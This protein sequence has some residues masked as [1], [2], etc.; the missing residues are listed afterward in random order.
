MLRFGKPTTSGDPCRC[1]LFASLSGAGTACWWRR[2]ASRLLR[3]ERGGRPV[4]SAGQPGELR[5][6]VV[7][8]M[9]SELAVGVRQVRFQFEQ[10][11]PAARAIFGAVSSV[12]R[13][14][15]ISVSRAVSLPRSHARGFRVERRVPFEL[16]ALGDVLDDAH[17]LVGSPMVTC[18]HRTGNGS[19]DD[20][21]VSGDE[22]RFGLVPLDVSFGRSVVEL[23]SVFQIVLV[24]ERFEGR[25]RA[26][27]PRT[28]EKS[29]ESRSRWLS[30]GRDRGSRSRWAP[31]ESST[32]P[33]DV[34]RSSS[35]IR[36]RSVT[37]PE[38]PLPDRRR[39]SRCAEASSSARRPGRLGIRARPCSRLRGCHLARPTL[40]VEMLRASQL[41]RHDRHPSRIG[42]R[43]RIR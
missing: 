31:V 39:R 7:S 23:G 1:Q 30:A 16:L 38:A 6:R 42:C 40:A 26:G 22:P 4:H 11:P 12:P 5:H 41:I 14:F 36:L 29:A 21:P 25:R 18:D 10:K 28:T 35:S 32:E 37:S 24:S 8:G 34:S 15:R 13:S 9:D 33:V 43:K 3:P 2:S 20:S 27:R 19:E 17:P